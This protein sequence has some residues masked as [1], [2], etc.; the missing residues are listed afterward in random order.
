MCWAIP[1]RRR[2]SF[3]CFSWGWSV[4]FSSSP[5]RF[6]F[7]CTR[8]CQ[9]LAVSFARRLVLLSRVYSSGPLSEGSPDVCGKE[10]RLGRR[11][12]LIGQGKHTIRAVIPDGADCSVCAKTV[13]VAAVQETQNAG[14]P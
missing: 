2:A 14:E 6:P 13:V 10:N 5:R 7:D 9:S 4:V 11:V 8:G 1:S 12:K 3:D